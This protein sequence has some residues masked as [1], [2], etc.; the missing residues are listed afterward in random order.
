MEGIAPET[1]LR[2]LLVG[3][4]DSRRVDTVINLGMD[5]QPFLGRG[6]R[7]Q[8]HDHLQTGE[9]LAAPVFAD[10]GKQAM[11]DFVPFAGSGW[12]VAGGDSE[13]GLVG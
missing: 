11:L 2:Y 3:Y 5:L 10:E 8:A 13:P 7:N 6:S 12:K 9:R 4:F 1:N